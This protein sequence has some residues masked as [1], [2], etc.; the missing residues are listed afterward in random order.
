[1]IYTNISPAF[2]THKSGSYQLAM[3]NQKLQIRKGGQHKPHVS[4]GPVFNQ[5][6]S[7]SHKVKG[8]ATSTMTQ[9][10]SS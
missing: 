9:H 7:L 4:L 1:M 3:H 5:Q 2:E 6:K 8:R 10:G